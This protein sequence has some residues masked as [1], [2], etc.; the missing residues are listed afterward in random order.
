M[1]KDRIALMV[2]N[3]LAAAIVM[4]MSV[5]WSDYGDEVEDVRPTRSREGQRGVNLKRQLDLMVVGEAIPAV[6]GEGPAIFLGGR[7]CS[8]SP[9]CGVSWSERQGRAI[10]AR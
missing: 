8:A 1:T 5:D 2:G 9:A 10:T 7:L 3:S 4:K 6:E